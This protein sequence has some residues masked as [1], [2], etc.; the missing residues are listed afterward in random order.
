M[1][2]Y[3]YIYMMVVGKWQSVISRDL[4]T[5]MWRG[6]GTFEEDTE[7]RSGEAEMSTGAITK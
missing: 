3:I 7:E 4:D 6:C 1:N 2:I 5:C